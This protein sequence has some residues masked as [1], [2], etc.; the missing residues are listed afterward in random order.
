[1]SGDSER[2]TGNPYIIL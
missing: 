2:I 1:M